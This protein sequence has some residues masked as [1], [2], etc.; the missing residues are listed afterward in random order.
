VTALAALTVAIPVAG[1]C[2]LVAGFCSGTEVALFSL[3]RVDLEQLVRS[4]V[5]ADRRILGLLERRSRLVATVL[6]GN[7]ASTGLLAVV[8]LGVVHHR[9]GSPLPWLSVIIAIA[10]ALPLIVL[11]AEVTAK[12][13]AAKAPMAWAR[14]ASL[15]LEF[16]ATVVTPLRWVVNVASWAVLRTFGTSARAR[17]ERDLS[18]QE[19]RSLVDAG[20]AQGEVDA[21][22]RRLIHRV[23]EFADKNVSQIMTPRSRVFALAYDLPMQRLVKEIAHHGFSRVPIYQKS[24]DNVRGIVNAKD[25][26]RAAIGLGPQKPLAELLYEPL[27]VPQTTPVKRLFLAFKQKKVHMAF[28]VSEYG[29]VLGLVTMDDVLAQ[30]FGVMRDERTELQRSRLG[31]RARVRTPGLGLPTKVDI[32]SGPIASGVNPRTHDP[33]ESQT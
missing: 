33:S 15:P 19:F 6:I 26:V 10:V 30:I 7:E 21:R 20:S 23:F 9:V 17:P 28:V 32:D 22:E 11:V 16:L 2:V 31:E 25:L 29:K 5:R 8:T 24:L 4:E 27:F 18:V 3:R 13:L 1:L 12:T 14:A